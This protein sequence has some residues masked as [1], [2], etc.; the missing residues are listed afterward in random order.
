[1]KT[2]ARIATI[3]GAA[4]GALLFAGAAARVEQCARVGGLELL[5]ELLD[6]GSG[7]IGRGAGGPGFAGVGGWS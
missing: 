5:A 1:M 3:G 7:S 6:R 2:T 4:A